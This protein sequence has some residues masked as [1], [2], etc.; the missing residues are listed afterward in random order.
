MNQDGPQAAREAGLRYVSDEIPGIRRV[1]RGKAFS[2]LGSDG[3]PITNEAELRRIKSIAVPPAYEHVWICPHANGHIQATA[4]DA[5]GRK[6]YRYHPKWREARDETKFHRMT[7]FAQALPRI[8]KRVERDL[9]TPG[10]PREKVLAAVVRLLEETTIRVGNSEYA[11]DNDSYGLTTMRNRH[12][13]IDGATVRF[14]F[15]GKSGIKHAVTLRDRKLV[16]IIR[17]CQDLPGQELFEYVDADGAPHSITSADV[18]GYIRDISD[19]DFT[20]KD[21]RTWVGS[22]ECLAILCKQKPVERPS[23]RKHTLNDVIAQVAKRLGNTSAVARK[24]YIHPAII[25]AFLAEGQIARQ[26]LRTFLKRLS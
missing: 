21:F 10:L 1:R 14:S 26:N 8:R 20:A 7:D 23:E 15:K 22:T 4:L 12:A 11:R 5:R 13:E 25:T 17:A 9:G 19:G 16:K 3:R 2:Y 24:S 6:Q 18:N